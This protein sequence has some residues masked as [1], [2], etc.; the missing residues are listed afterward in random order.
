MVQRL[1]SD[2]YVAFHKFRQVDVPELECDREGEKLD[3]ALVYLE[4]LLEVLVLFEE[5]RIVDDDL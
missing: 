5:C 4:A 3:T 1:E 2:P